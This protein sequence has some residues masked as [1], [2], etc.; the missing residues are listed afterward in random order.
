MPV[1]CALVAVVV[2]AAVV[3]AVASPRAVA[4]TIT[5]TAPEGTATYH[6]GDALPVAWTL[7]AQ[8]TGGY[9]CVYI[10]D[11]SGAV[12]QVESV[13]ASRSLSYATVITLDLAAGQSY[14]VTVKYRPNRTSDFTMSADSPGTFTIPALPFPFQ[15]EAYS[16]A[17][18]SVVRGYSYTFR[19]WVLH[20][21]PGAVIVSGVV[22][23]RS[24][25]TLAWVATRA[26]TDIAPGAWF[27]T[28]SWDE[29][30]PPNATTMVCD[31]PVGNYVWMV[32]VTSDTG[33]SAGGAEGYLGVTRR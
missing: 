17:G 28:S 13:R 14:Y 19:F 12:Q 33:A 3:T 9:F 30:P 11:S 31:L 6:S 4:T 8:V 20:P 23:F 16:P 27:I 1:F 29:T 25:R 22:E 2:L 7:D 15:T 24:A 26:I 32:R 21:D 10:K 5:V 18:E